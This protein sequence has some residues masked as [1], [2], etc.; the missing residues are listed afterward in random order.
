[1]SENEATAIIAAVC[2]QSGKFHPLSA[3]TPT[4]GGWRIEFEQPSVKPD[5]VAEWFSKCGATVTM[6]GVTNVY[7]DV[8]TWVVEFRR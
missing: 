2:Q 3:P 4:V 6:C 7:A 8:P 1:M 5:A